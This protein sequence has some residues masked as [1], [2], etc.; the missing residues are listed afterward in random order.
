[1]IKLD[2]CLYNSRTYL[3][4]FKY[5]LGIKLIV[6]KNQQGLYCIIFSEINKFRSSKFLSLSINLVPAYVAS[7]MATHVRG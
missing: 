3:T 2:I 1:M 6:C 7:D 5:N 4:V